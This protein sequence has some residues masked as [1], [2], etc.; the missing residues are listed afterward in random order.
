[1]MVPSKHH[2]LASVGLPR[3]LYRAG[4]PGY[5]KPR[6]SDWVPQRKATIHMLLLWILA[7]L[8]IEL[9]LSIGGAVLQVLV[10]NIH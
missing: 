8:L 4:G 7:Y 5:G 9:A 1:M 3:P 6:A 10:D 2:A